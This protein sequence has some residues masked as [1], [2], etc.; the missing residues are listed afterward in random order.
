[1]F[2]LGFFSSLKINIFGEIFLG[3]IILGGCVLLNILQNLFLGKRIVVPPFFV[4]I[5]WILLV[6]LFCQILSDVVN[7]TDFLS[8]IKGEFVPVFIFLIYWGLSILFSGG[9][10]YSYFYGLFLGYLFFKYLSGHEYFL[11]NSWKFGGGVI[12]GLVAFMLVDNYKGYSK[13]RMILFLGGVFFLVSLI[14]SSRA[15]AGFF[16]FS[17]AVSVFVNEEKYSR[18]IRMLLGNRAKSVKLVV[19]SVLFL[20]LLD[21]SLYML[22]TYEPF[23]NILSESA[24]YKY[25][26]QALSEYGVILGG[27]NELL[28]SVQAFF[29][30]PILG[31]GSWAENIKYVHM[32]YDY[33]AM[34][35]DWIVNLEQVENHLNRYLIPTHSFLM[36]ALVWGGIFA[37][38]FWIRVLGLCIQIFQV[39]SMVTSPFYFF[40]VLNV[41]WNVLFSPFG[42]DARWINMVVIW[43]L[44]MRLNVEIR[45]IKPSG[46]ENE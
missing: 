30:K 20:F 31:H 21:R 8:A 11:F 19:I 26:S 36:G 10:R 7:E 34:Q 45:N 39:P 28:V 13:K 41:F 37:G 40:A 14:N 1:M 16:V 23:L 25:K 12:L 29:D 5:F 2:F 9:I 15:L 24:A 46:N 6:W 3:E 38:L 43:L 33:L 42:A 44:V 35:D 4:Q 27:R 32:R 18:F 22:F 17:A